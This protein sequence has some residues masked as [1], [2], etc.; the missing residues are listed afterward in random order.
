MKYNGESAK[1]WLADSL[2]SPMPSL[3]ELQPTGLYVY[4]R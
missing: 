1:G 2:D 4:V 3:P